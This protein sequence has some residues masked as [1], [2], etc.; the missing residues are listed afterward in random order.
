[1]RI[2]LVAEAVAQFLEGD[3]D[4]AVAVGCPRSDRVLVRRDPEEDEGSDPERRQSLALQ[5]QRLDRV[6]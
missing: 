2:D 4:N 1:M 3:L 5:H 6:L